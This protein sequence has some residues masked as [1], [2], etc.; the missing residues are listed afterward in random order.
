M[1]GTTND[2][3]DFRPPR[4]LSFNYLS[5]KICRTAERISEVRLTTIP[6]VSDLSAQ[7]IRAEIGGD[8]S[9]FPTVGHLVSWAG[10]RPK[11]DESAG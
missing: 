4:P 1:V 2:F 10:L 6:R 7:V 3:A 11:N 5:R 8:M 9:R